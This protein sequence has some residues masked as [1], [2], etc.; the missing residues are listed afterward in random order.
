MSGFRML[1]SESTSA[2]RLQHELAGF[3]S[4]GNASCAAAALSNLVALG[5]DHLPLPGSGHTLARWQA[6]AEVAAHDLSLAKLYEGHTDALAILSEL[7]VAVPALENTARF[8]AGQFH[9]WGVWAA[10]PPEFRVTFDPS[11]ARPEEPVVLH[12]I[13]AWCSGAASASH[14]LMTVWPIDAS[15]PQLVAL[16][17]SQQQ[18][19]VSGDKW[20]AVGM[21]GS[22][23]LQ[24]DCEGAQA[25]LIGAP[26][27]YLS[28]AGFW[29]G[30]AGVAACWYGGTL[31]IARALRENLKRASTRPVS[32]LETLGRIDVA[33]MS[34]AGLL[35]QAAAWIDAHPQD[36][37]REVALRVRLA[38]ADCAMAVL[39][40]VGDVLGPTP[41]CH[42]AGFAQ[43]AADLPVFVRQSHAHRDHVALGDCIAHEKAE[44]WTL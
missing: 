26:G 8:D 29:Q 2:L 18:V 15:Q 5:L 23:S 20:Q 33:L 40:E 4:S 44:T 30:G 38:A 21:R 10:E 36:D 9:S 22:A 24:V 31:R 12:G 7:K 27:A 34:T 19:K 35:R 39:R 43:A 16:D 6:L 41:F 37:A 42:D 14:A 1:G 17:L 13:K 3:A 32:H 28:R 25:W 11:N